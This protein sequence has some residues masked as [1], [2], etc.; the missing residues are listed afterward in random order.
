MQR[1]D[2]KIQR[3]KIDRKINFFSLIID[4]LKVDDIYL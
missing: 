3:W 1:F 4:F 2:E